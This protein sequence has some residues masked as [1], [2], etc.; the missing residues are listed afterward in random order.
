MDGVEKRWKKE[1]EKRVANSLKKSKSEGEWVKVIEDN[2]IEDFFYTVC[3][4][5]AMSIILT[6]VQVPN[7]C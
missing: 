7:R 5:T 4:K 2:V 6:M 3:F 1:K